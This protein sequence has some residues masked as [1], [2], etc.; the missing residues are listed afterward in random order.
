[1]RK[2]GIMNTTH[3]T[4]SL[5][6]SEARPPAAP[7]AIG[8]AGGTSVVAALV[9]ELGIMLVAVAKVV[10]AEEPSFVTLIGSKCDD[11]EGV[12]VVEASDKVVGATLE[13]VKMLEDGPKLDNG[14]NEYDVRKV[15]DATLEAS[16][17]MDI[18][19]DVR[20]EMVLD[21]PDGGGVCVV[22]GVVGAALVEMTGVFDVATVAVTTIKD[23]TT[24][25]FGTGAD[26]LAEITGGTGIVPDGAA[27]EL[28]DVGMIIVVGTTTVPDGQM[29]TVMEIE[30]STNDTG[31]EIEPEVAAGGMTTVV[32]SGGT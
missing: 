7:L 16:E 4:F 11:G 2:R 31:I 9:L 3:H 27:F 28:A 12:G 20:G 13:D 5:F 6:L 23:D 1:M 10:R 19:S 29:T 32:G 14:I 18:S 25:E 15:S 21:A 30:G 22:V 8:G 26:K 24:V 17:M